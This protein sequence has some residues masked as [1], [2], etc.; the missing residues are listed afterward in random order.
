MLQMALL[1]GKDPT[2]FVSQTAIKGHDE[3][4]RSKK[5]QVFASSTYEALGLPKNKGGT[6]NSKI[7]VTSRKLHKLRYS[8][9]QLICASLLMES[10]K[11]S[12]LWNITDLEM[13]RFLPTQFISSKTRIV[14]ANIFSPTVNFISRILKEQHK[15][16][17]AFF[18][19]NAF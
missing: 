7:Q 5:A 3:K 4:D 16:K 10:S 1:R 11:S 13:S 2:P 19:D 8:P 18:D 12:L 14:P 6:F 15:T 9:K 17:G